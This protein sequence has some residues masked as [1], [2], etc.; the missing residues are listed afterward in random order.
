M[1]TENTI[2]TTSFREPSQALAAI[3]RPETPSTARA[4]FAVCAL[5]SPRHRAILLGYQRAN[6]RSTPDVLKRISDDVWNMSLS[7][8]RICSGVIRLGALAAPHAPRIPFCGC[9]MK[10]AC[11]N[12]RDTVETDACAKAA[13]APAIKPRTTSGDRSIACAHVSICV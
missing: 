13:N 4:S 5:P 8:H 12:K 10:H 7:R 2:R 11:Q 1:N 6:S 3:V 9:R